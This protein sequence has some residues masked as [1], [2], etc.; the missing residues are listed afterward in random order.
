MLSVTCNNQ[1]DPDLNRTDELQDL[2][3]RKFRR[4]TARASERISLC[5]VK[6]GRTTQS[7]YH[8]FRSLFPDILKLP[9]KEQSRVCE[10][11]LTTL[12][13]FVDEEEADPL[14][15]LYFQNCQCQCISW[16][17]LRI[18]AHFPHSSTSQ[19]FINLKMCG[20]ATP[21]GTMPCHNFMIVC[22][23]KY[24]RHLLYLFFLLYFNFILNLGKFYLLCYDMCLQ[25]FH[26]NKWKFKFWKC[27]YS[28]RN[29]TMKWL[30]A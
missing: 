7:R 28:Y 6:T 30:A 19:L 14:R 15:K 12:N 27:L 1:M 3:V 20:V 24:L 23:W 21:A 25:L 13:Q 10:T 26:S 8:V 18:M 5:L 29:P 17:V 22:Y 11:V 2:P 9:G 4:P 16:N